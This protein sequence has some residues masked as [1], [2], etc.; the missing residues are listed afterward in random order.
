[1]RLALCGL[2]AATAAL[3]ALAIYEALHAWPLYRA[4]WYHFDIPLGSG[5]SVKMRSGLLRSPGPFPE[6]TSF[7]FCLA[8][9]TLAAVTTRS[10]FRGRAR[11]ALVLVLLLLGII[12][13]Q[14]RGAWLGIAV[15][16]IAADLYRSRLA[17]LGRTFAGIALAT[18]L[19][20]GLATVSSRVANIAG[21]NGEGAG[22]VD[23]RASL[24]QRGLQE[25]K[26]H[27]VM[28]QDLQAVMKNLSDLRQGEGVIDFVNSYIYI[29]LVAGLIGLTIIVAAVGWKMLNVWQVR[30]QLESAFD[31]F[32][33]GGFVFSANAAI[34]VMLTLTSL[35][36]RTAGMLIIMVAFAAVLVQVAKQRAAVLLAGRTVEAA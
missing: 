4:V 34:L 36:E 19:F 2:V 17:A 12:A 21:L 6:P 35:V 31:H 27:P 22:S 28:G 20:L 15:G 33:L 7:G 16:V 11:H 13:P 9:G 14:S 10:I 1:M 23:Y 30:R 5:A 29:A 32:A 24:F 3:S 26:L 18:A 8:L 25:I